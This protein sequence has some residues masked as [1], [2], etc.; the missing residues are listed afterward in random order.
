MPQSSSA[1]SVR[2]PLRGAAR[3]QAILDATLELLGELGYDRVTCDGIA[4]RAH[5]SKATIY[6]KWPD[7]A[8]LVA[9]ALRRQADDGPL[10]V[11]SSGSVRGDLVAHVG[12]LARSLVGGATPSVLQVLERV[13]DDDAL[14]RRVAEQVRAR[15][16]TVAQAVCDAA[17]AR[18]EDVD[19]ARLQDVLEVAHAQVLVR[20]LLDGSVPDAAAQERLVDA[21]LL[22]LLRP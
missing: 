20:S 14:R 11:V 2:S 10:P 3:E 16:A 4:A 15:A 9:D 18:G 6:R 12:E 19:V 5:A 22:P 21:V 8:A 1:Q 17:A 13:R 7:K